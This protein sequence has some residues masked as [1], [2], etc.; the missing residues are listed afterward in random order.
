[1]DFS[2]LYLRFG[3]VVDFVVV[4]NIQKYMFTGRYIQIPKIRRIPGSVM[5]CQQI[6]LQIVNTDGMS[7]YAPIFPQNP[8]G[9]VVNVSSIRVYG[10]LD[11]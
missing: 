10:P 11:N 7:V 5:V 3:K 6:S 4:L 8:Q 1:M 9:P 2:R